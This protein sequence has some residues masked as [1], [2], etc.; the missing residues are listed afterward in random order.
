M[1]RG[2]RKPRRKPMPML[3]RLGGALL[4][5]AAVAAMAGLSA[6]PAFAGP[7]AK[8]V[9]WTVTPGGSVTGTAGTTTLKDATTGTTLTCTSSQA[10]GTLQSGSGLGNP[11]GMIQALSF[12]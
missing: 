1:D 8:A 6:G 3:T 5:T 10:T 12:T 7:A 2:K 4:T 11:L 9:T